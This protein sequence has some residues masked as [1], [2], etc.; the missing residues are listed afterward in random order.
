ML[1]SLY[2]HRLLSRSYP[3]FLVTS[4]WTTLWKWSQVREE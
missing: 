2:H 4:N 1:Q 3:E